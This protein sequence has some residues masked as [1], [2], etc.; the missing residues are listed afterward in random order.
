MIACACKEIV[1]GHHSSIGPFDPHIFG[2]LSA[3]GILEE[4]KML[5]ITH[6][7]DPSSLPDLANNN[8]SLS[9]NYF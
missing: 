3:Y 8:L 2:G 7:K 1:M 9:T 5:S 6:S 4:L